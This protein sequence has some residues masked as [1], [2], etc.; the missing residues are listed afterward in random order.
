MELI[1]HCEACGKPLF[2]GDDHQFDPEGIVWVCRSCVEDQEERLREEFG[3]IGA[4]RG[5]GAGKFVPQ[6]HALTCEHRS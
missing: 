4:G 2:E 1:A 6:P 5:D 3:W